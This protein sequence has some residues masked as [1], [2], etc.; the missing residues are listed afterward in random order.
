MHGILETAMHSGRSAVSP[1]VHLLLALPV[2]RF[3]EKHA[4]RF[5]EKPCIAV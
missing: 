1:T 5:F 2:H 4:H 3:F